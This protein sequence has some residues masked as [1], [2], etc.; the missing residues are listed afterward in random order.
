MSLSREDLEQVGVYVRSHLNEWLPR[1]V[2]DLQ[3]RIIRVEDELRAQ[4]EVMIAR[5]DANDKRFDEQLAH[6]NER[7]K[8][9]QAQMDAR[10]E[11]VNQRFEDVN[12]RFDDVNQR[13][14]DVNRRFEDMNRRFE[15]TQAQM[16]AR[17]ED[18]RTQMDARFEEARVQSDTRFEAFQKQ[19]DTRFR[20]VDHHLRVHEWLIGGGMVL[21]AT[22]MTLYQ[23]LA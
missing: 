5:F 10:F 6:M 22:M 20:H 3:E 18:V 13:F 1:E 12:R 14:E 11:D 8:E 2:F 15:E 17:F 7:F 9:Q 21:L 4:R 16:D 19:L 23:F